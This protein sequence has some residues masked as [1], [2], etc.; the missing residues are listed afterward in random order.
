MNVVG[1]PS[2]A[3]FSCIEPRDR[4]LERKDITVTMGLAVAVPRA[5]GNAPFH[6]GVWRRLGCLRESSGGLCAGSANDGLSSLSAFRS[7]P[8][9]VSTRWPT[10][11][12]GSTPTPQG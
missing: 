7:T 6:L 9:P 8:A 4:R 10:P 11:F 5:P 12:K 3:A 1:S 2:E